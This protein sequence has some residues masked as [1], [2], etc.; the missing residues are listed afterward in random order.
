LPTPVLK[1]I[2]VAGAQIG[3]D[4]CANA[5]VHASAHPDD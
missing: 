1:T 4:A 2:V 5:A 3:V